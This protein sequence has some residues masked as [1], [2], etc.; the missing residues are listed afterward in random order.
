LAVLL[1]ACGSISP[2]V[3]PTVSPAPDSTG[4]SPT[5]APTPTLTPLPMSTRTL[6]L[7]IGTGTMLSLSVPEGTHRAHTDVAVAISGATWQPAGAC[8][9]QPQGEFLT[10]TLRETIVQG[11]GARFSPLDFQYIASI[12]KEANRAPFSGCDHPLLSSTMRPAKGI[13]VGQMTYDV[14]TGHSGT[15]V[16]KIFDE[17]SRKVET[18][19]SWVIS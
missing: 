3:V 5:R 11:P 19:A 17:A 14:S 9:T 8:G 18:A 10:V 15:V 16:L 13:L 7:P 1:A 2:A 4:S 6:Q 12:G